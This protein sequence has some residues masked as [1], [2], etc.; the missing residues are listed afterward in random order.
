[1]EILNKDSII[2][3]K[4]RKGYLIHNIRD[5][6]YA[7][8]IYLGKNANLDDYEEVPDEK[9]L[10]K[11]YDELEH[12]FSCEESLM[13]I[14]KI[15]ARQTTDDAQALDIQEFYDEWMYDIQY[16][17]DQ[18][19]RYREVLYKIL[20]DHVSQ[21]TWKPDVTPSLYA[22]VLIDPTGETI[23]DWVQPDSTNPY[24]VGDKVKFED[25]IYE[26]LIDNNVWSPAAYPAAWKLIE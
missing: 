9:Y 12:L 26:S 25:H 4:S 6:L 13:K 14:A 22:K 23:L 24:M 3:L 21:K 5:D 2:I 15:I 10:D 20:V 1:M 17:K 7:E 8:V 19:V 11:I 18:Y 16:Y